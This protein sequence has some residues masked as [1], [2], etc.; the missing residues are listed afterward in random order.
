MKNKRFIILGILVFVGLAGAMIGLN[1]F[2]QTHEGLEHLKADH[3]ID[4]AK[5]FTAF[6]ENETQANELYLGKIIEVQGRISSIEVPSEGTANIVLEAS[7]D[8]FGGINCSF[9]EIDAKQVSTFEKGQNLRIRGECS[10]FLMDVTLVRCV[11]I[12]G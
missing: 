8:S 6:E 3:E 4:A 2:T 10:G 7:E 11:I 5:L 1:M 9:T 12:P